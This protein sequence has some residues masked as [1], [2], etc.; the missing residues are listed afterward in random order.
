MKEKI[1]DLIIINNKVHI[2]TINKKDK[3]KSENK[4]E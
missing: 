3:W 4:N 1:M 2:L